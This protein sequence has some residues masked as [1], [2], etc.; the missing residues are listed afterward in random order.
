MGSGRRWEGNLFCTQL[1]R[2]TTGHSRPFALCRVS[3]CTAGVS[4]SASATAGSS[5][6]SMSASRWLTNSRTLSYWSTC[7]ASLTRWKNLLTFCTSCSSSAG[8]FAYRVMRPGVEQELVEELPRGALARQLHVALEIGDHP[9]HRRHALLAQTDLIRHGAQHVEEPPVLP[10]GVGRALRQVD[11]GDLVD[12]RR[13]EVVQA[14]GIVRMGDGA[15]ER[16]QQPHLRP[17]VEPGVA[18]EGPRDAAHV[19]RAEEGVGVV[20]GPDEDR[21]VLVRPALCVLLRD[22]RGHAVGLA[23][24]RVEGEV[25]GGRSASAPAPTLVSRLLMPYFASSR[26]GLLYWISR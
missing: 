15:E 20:V 26:S 23:R 25:L 16:D 4:L 11:D 14:D 17:A 12:V 19:E 2:K 18:G 24:H 22:H 5:P 9:A 13:R 7:E 3:T 21:E 10:V 1:T 6:A 8:A